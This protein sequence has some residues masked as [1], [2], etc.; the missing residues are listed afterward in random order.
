MIPFVTLSFYTGPVTK[1]LGGADLAFAV[2]LLVSGVLHYVLARGVDQHDASL[3][4]EEV[5]VPA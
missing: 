2:G 5:R 4:A 1:A 3:P